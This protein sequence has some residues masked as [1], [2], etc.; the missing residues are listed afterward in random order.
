[1]DWRRGFGFG[2]F[3][4]ENAWCDDLRAAVTDVA[5]DF[6]DAPSWKSHIVV[7]PKLRRPGT[8]G[9]FSVIGDVYVGIYGVWDSPGDD[10]ICIDWVRRVSATLDAHAVGHYVNEI[11]AAHAPQRLRRCYSETAWNRL[12]QVRADRDPD[13]VLHDFAGLS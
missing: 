1:M 2:R 3:A 9:A 8:G 11:D 6:V 4:V 13:G 12:R 7:Q 5:R 10:G